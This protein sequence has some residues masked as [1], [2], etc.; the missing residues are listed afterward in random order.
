MDEMSVLD[1]LKLKL[2]PQNWHRPILP[3]ESGFKQPKRSLM[4]SLYEIEQT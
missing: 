2:K 3:E 4:K 1:Y